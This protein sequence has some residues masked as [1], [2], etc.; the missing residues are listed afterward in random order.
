MKIEI[1][2][3]PKKYAVEEIK[4]ADG[5]YEKR[6]VDLRT[7]QTYFASDEEDDADD[8][9][10]KR[11]RA[12][13][14]KMKEAPKANLAG[15]K[16]RQTDA[17]ADQI[18][19]TQ[20][21]SKSVAEAVSDNNN[22]ENMKNSEK[23]NEAE[24]EAK[25]EAATKDKQVDR[26]TDAK[27]AAE[28]EEAKKTIDDAVDLTEEKSPSHMTYV[29]KIMARHDEENEPY[30]RVEER[31]AH[32]SDDVNNEIFVNQLN[33]AFKQMEIDAYCELDKQ[34]FEDDRADDARK[35][36]LNICGECGDQKEDFLLIKLTKKFEYGESQR[37]TIPA[38]ESVCG[39]P[40]CSPTCIMKKALGALVELEGKMA[41]SELNCNGN[42]REKLRSDRARIL[43]Y[44]DSFKGEFEERLEIHNKSDKDMLENYASE[45]VA[46]EKLFYVAEAV[47]Q[48]MKEIFESLVQRKAKPS[49]QYHLERTE[50]QETM[51]AGMQEKLK[52]VADYY[53]P[54]EK[55][56]ERQLNFK[57]LTPNPYKKVLQNMLESESKLKQN[58]VYN[59]Q[60]AWTSTKEQRA[61][62]Q[63]RQDTAKA[64]F[65][66]KILE[67]NVWRN[68]RSIGEDLAIM[69]PNHTEYEKAHKAWNRNKGQEFPEIEPKALV[70]IAEPPNLYVLR[71]MV[72]KLCHYIENLREIVRDREKLTVKLCEAK[73]TRDNYRIMANWILKRSERDGA[74]RAEM[75]DQEAQIDKNAEH[76]AQQTKTLI[77][78]K[79]QEEDI[80]QKANDIN[81]SEILQRQKQVELDKREEVLARSEKAKSEAKNLQEIYE[82]EKK[83]MKEEFRQNRVDLEKVSCDRW[84]DHYKAEYNSAVARMSELKDNLQL[85]KSNLNKDM[86]ELKA[87]AA[88]LEA[89]K[90][91]FETLRATWRSEK[92]VLETRLA[93]L[94]GENERMKGKQ[95]AEILNFEDNNEITRLE[96]ENSELREQ[97]RAKDKELQ[98][99]KSDLAK[100]GKELEEKSKEIIKLKGETADVKRIR[101]ERDRAKADLERK[102]DEARKANTTLDKEKEETLLRIKE[103]DDLVAKWQA[104][105]EKWRIDKEASDK[106]REEEIKKNA[107]LEHQLKVM[108]QGHEDL[109]SEHTRIKADYE[110]IR[111]EYEAQAQQR[112]FFY[113]PYAN[114]P[115]A[116][117]Y[118]YGG[119]TP[120]AQQYPGP[121]NWP[122]RQE[123][124]ARE[125]TIEKPAARASEE[126]QPRRAVSPAKQLDN[127]RQ[128]NG[129]EPRG[130]QCS[131]PAQGNQERKAEKSS[132]DGSKKS[133]E[134][135]A[136]QGE[137]QRNE[138]KDRERERFNKERQREREK[139]D[140]HIT[141]RSQEKF[142]SERPKE[143]KPRDNTPD[144]WAVSPRRER[145]EGR[146][147][148]RDE[149]PTQIKRIVLR[150]Q[151]SKHEKREASP[152]R[153]R[154]DEHEGADER[155]SKRRQKES[156][157]ASHTVDV[158]KQLA[159]LQQEMADLKKSQ[160]SKSN[161]SNEKR[162]MQSASSEASPNERS[163]RVV[164]PPGETQ[165]EPRAEQRSCIFWSRGF[166][167]EGANC[168]FKHTAGVTQNPP[169]CKFLLERGNCC[170]KDCAYKHE[171][172]QP[173]T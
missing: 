43:A 117:A 26:D 93:T 15:A 165:R 81:A 72:I 169:P 162:A 142:S 86:E 128:D 74:E 16:E 54:I 107:D 47:V 167:N 36:V 153:K 104:H 37:H 131:T 35:S 67:E 139:E 29:E 18:P 136:S 115:S 141:E 63:F 17:N 170:K 2:M 73:R 6:K 79:K 143:K 71:M 77:E 132:K 146:D 96:E 64:M 129:D 111:N 94:Q 8:R 137:R 102:T 166:C 98:T 150:K 106:L 95:T 155:G 112:Q 124:E 19:D 97:M 163:E 164:Q 30:L 60:D 145:N 157:D 144:Q 135:R 173:A 27:S 12:D 44:I 148:E 55:V 92:T 75:K 114:Q 116:N 69:E 21:V 39:G 171:K 45:G 83:K 76:I 7:S 159:A 25:T 156:M 41:Q 127:L 118:A 113:L 62:L 61:Q 3:P 50:E 46:V 108:F 70:T 34:P 5:S 80:M 48:R 149:R 151:E 1:E 158:M 120:Q 82:E 161:E 103:R 84:R 152:K 28:G 32:I 90:A 38:V 172:P 51:I 11:K 160:Q 122:L 126:E 53:E 154:K 49:G 66:V 109:Q 9:E 99:N 59:Q 4:N 121:P 57:E 23:M 13:D 91:K 87:K 138:A 168:K 22:N 130:P 110:R 33:E 24:D 58:A 10:A 105:S 101:G 147:E 20:S 31:E 85:C 78:L 68:L 133:T 140:R 40:V 88:D 42:Q 14:D 65:A 89:D 123:L 119:Y 52:V 56:L 100:T 125:A 134:R